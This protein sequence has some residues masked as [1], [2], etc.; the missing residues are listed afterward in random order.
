[1]YIV[2]DAMGGDNAPEEIVRGSISALEDL[3]DLNIILTGKKSQII[4]FLSEKEQREDL[5]IL[6][7]EEVIEMNEKPARALKRKK[8]TSIGRAADL[9]ASDKAQALVSA[10]STGAS[11]AAGI[12]KI[13]RLSGI[14]RPAISV[15]LPTK[16]KPVLLLDVGANANC[17]SFYLKQFAV[18]GQIYSK[19]IMNRDNPA[20]GLMNV[21]EEEGKGNKMIDEAFELISEDDRIKNFRGNIEGRDIFTGEL[22]VILCDGFAGNVI[23]KTMEGLGEYIFSLLKDVF[24]DNLKTKIGGFLVKNSLQNMKSEVDYRQYGGAPMLGL[25]G[26]VIISH[27]SS[28]ALAIKNAIKAAARTVENDI[29]PIIDDEIN[30]DGE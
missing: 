23:L 11:L 19:N 28:D 21:G 27:G 15:V 18:M 12:I 10:G 4:S 13:G 1:M 16:K 26:N 17:E 14:K 9:V 2:V 24:T 6:D 29:V 5:E 30:R 3:E 22:D 20:I 25:K 8:D 7:C